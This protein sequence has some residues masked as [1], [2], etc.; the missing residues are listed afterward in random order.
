M[1]G[2]VNFDFMGPLHRAINLI[3]PLILTA[4]GVGGVVYFYFIVTTWPLWITIVASI[5]GA[6]GLCIGFGKNT[7]TWVSNHGIDAISELAKLLTRDEARPIA[8]NIA[9]LPEMLRRPN[10]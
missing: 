4:I 10:Q 9:K 8:A 3:V 1:V 2:S 7:L 5:I 6:S